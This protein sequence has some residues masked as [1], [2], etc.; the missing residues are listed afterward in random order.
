MTSDVSAHDVRPWGSYY[1]VDT[2]PGYKTKRLVVHPGGRLS[3]QRHRRRAEHWFVVIGE[4]QVTLDGGE[5][6]L[7]AGESIDIPLGV[8]HRVANNGPGE[9]VLVEVQTGDYFGEDDIE[10]LDDDYGRAP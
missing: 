3:Y 5:C 4:A 7:Y 8:A 10:R 9:L 1:V 6:T 2:G